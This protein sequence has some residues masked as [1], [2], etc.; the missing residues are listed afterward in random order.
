[1]NCHLL[2][3]ETFLITVLTRMYYR[4]KDDKVGYEP[5]SSPDLDVNLKAWGGWFGQWKGHCTHETGTRFL[6]CPSTLAKWK[7]IPLSAQAGQLHLTIEMKVNYIIGWNCFGY[8]LWR[9][10]KFCNRQTG[11]TLKFCKWAHCPCGCQP[12]SALKVCVLKSHSD[13]LKREEY[14]V[15][16]LVLE[17]DRIQP[18]RNSTSPVSNKSGFWRTNQRCSFPYTHI[19]RTWWH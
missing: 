10:F 19:S 2:I 13:F 11:W 16:C 6:H 4:R 5:F 8:C 12:L 7:R 17:Q 9:Y 15:V 14:M 18:S 3:L 1:M